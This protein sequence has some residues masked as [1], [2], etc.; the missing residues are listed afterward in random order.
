MGYDQKVIS[1][2]YKEIFFR[3][4]DYFPNPSKDVVFFEKSV[5]Y[6]DNRYVPKRLSAV[7]PKIFI[8]IVLIDPSERAYSCY[9][10]RK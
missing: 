2:I 10:V 1:S 5:T 9:Q 8:V 3:Y 6:F 7:L 4:M